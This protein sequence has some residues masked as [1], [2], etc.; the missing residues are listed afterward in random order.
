MRSV[1][2]LSSVLLLSLVSLLAFCVYLLTL[3]PDLTWA[4]NGVDGGELITAVYTHGLPHP[5]G[6]PLYRLLGQ[7]IGRLPLYPIA[8]RFNLFS[9]IAA[10]LAAGVVSVTV[11][12]TAAERRSGSLTAVAVGLTLAFAALVW[13]QATITEVYGLALLLLALFLWALL[14]ERPSWLTGLFLGLSLTA[15]LTAWLM[16]PLALALTPRRRWPRLLAGLLV[17][18][19]PLALLP[20]LADP[21][22]PVVWGD[23]TT[24]RGWWWLVSGQL[25]R[26]YTFALPLADLP[27]R[28]TAWTPILLSQFTWAGIPLIVA[29]VM[30]LPRSERR[31]AY[32]LAATAVLYLLFALFYLPDDAIN[33]TLPAWLLL[34]LLL[35]PAYQRLSILAL[36]LPLILLLINF[37]GQNLRADQQVRERAEALLPAIPRAAIVETPGDPTIF[38]LWYFQHVEG[39]RPDV[40]LVDEDLFAHDWYRARLAS[41]YPALAGLEQPDL[42]VFQAANVGERPYCQA[43][44]N[45]HLAPYNLTCAEETS[46]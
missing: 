25:Y 19:L 9:A 24:L 23:P 15:H 16:L 21:A 22:S 2:R 6:Y 4:N 7:V 32:G 14:T 34:G 17:G 45:T 35:S 31:V 11:Y 39:Q 12:Q 27:T 18:L 3:A 28:L 20:W 13:S 33:H 41:L 1:G 44:I 36:C 37:S 29:G 30:M 5:P 43:T 26:G 46:S 38:A 40:V 42:S 10:A 8:Y